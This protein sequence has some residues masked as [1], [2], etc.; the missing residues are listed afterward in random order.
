MPDEEQRLAQGPSVVGANAFPPTVPGCGVAGPHQDRDV[1]DDRHHHVRD[2]VRPIVGGREG[3]TERRR[4]TTTN[5]LTGPTCVTTNCSRARVLATYSRFRSR[6]RA[7]A[8]GAPRI[9]EWCGT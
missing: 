8:F 4:W 6:S 1:L 3:L 7:F 9:T 5:S 2:E